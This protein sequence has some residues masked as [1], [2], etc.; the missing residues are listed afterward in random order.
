MA[1]YYYAIKGMFL[2]GLAR[3]FVKYE[4]LQNHFLFMALLYTAGIAGLSWVFRPAIAPQMTQR[5]WLLGLA[6]SFV[7]CLVYFRLLAR[8]DEGMIFW[9]LFLGGAAGLIWL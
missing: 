4:P 8:F 7:A 1:L 2:I 9:L 5:D 6:K 3:S